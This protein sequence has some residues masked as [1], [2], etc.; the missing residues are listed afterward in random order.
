MTD[1]NCYM[2]E[3][4]RRYLEQRVGAQSDHNQS[5]RASLF[6]DL[7]SETAALLDFGCGTGGVLERLRC[8]SRIGI[9]ISPFAAEQAR[10][11]GVEVCS[12]LQ[13]VSDQSI[14][15]AIS[16]HALEH[17][18][19][20]LGI[21]KQIRRVLKPNGRVRVVVPCETPIL[22]AQRSWH[23]NPDRHLYTWTP[24]LL[25]NLAERAGFAE[26]RSRAQPMPTGS[27]LVRAA[28]L[29]PSV[30]PLVHL[31]LSVRRNTLNVILDARA[32]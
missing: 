17:V 5:M 25:G 18:D 19:D 10:T 26:I 24:L 32:P 8:R 23:V 22:T 15:V 12:A 16:F 20:P 11:K 1:D 27:R 4:G 6:R 3:T 7:E 13:D 31:L 21:L 2:G 14:D 28:R 29:I 9:E 30:A